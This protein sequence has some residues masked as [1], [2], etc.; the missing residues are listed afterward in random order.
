MPT[1]D[2]PVEIRDKTER[3]WRFRMRHQ[4]IYH[5]FEKPEPQKPDSN[6]ARTR[7]LE[8]NDI[9]TEFFDAGIGCCWFARQGDEEPV[10][11]ATEAD[12]IARLACVNALEFMREIFSGL[13]CY[14]NET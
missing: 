4:T 8:A 6:A 13:S 7:W 3:P 5:V 11:G 9:H 1:C 2:F 10:T 14:K 12:A